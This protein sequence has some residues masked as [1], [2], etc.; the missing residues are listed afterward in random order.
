MTSTNIRRPNA[1]KHDTQE[2]DPRPHAAQFAEAA[3]LINNA[4]RVALITHM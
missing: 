4:T 2:L 3:A 1:A